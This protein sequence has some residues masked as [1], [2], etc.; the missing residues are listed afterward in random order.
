VAAVI[1]AAV[2]LVSVVVNAR[3]RRGHARQASPPAA[4]AQDAARALRPLAGA[5]AADL[6]A[7]GLVTSALVALPVVMA[8]TAYVVGAHFNWRRG[9]S[10]RA[11]R[12]RRFCAIL[13]ASIGLALVV[14]G[15]KIAVIGMLVAA[16]VTRGFGTPSVWCSWSAWPAI[17]RSCDRSASPGG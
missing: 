7:A 3:R 17:P 6:F 15:A 8:S 1:V 4:S 16:S 13:A 14:S 10:E 11:C 2:I 12:A 9:L 5:A